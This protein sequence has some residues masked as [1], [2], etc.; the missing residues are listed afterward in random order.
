[1]SLLRPY[2]QFFLLFSF[3]QGKYWVDPNEGCYNDAEYVY[4]DFERGAT[5]VFP[6]NKEVR[7]ITTLLIIYLPFIIVNFS[8]APSM[9]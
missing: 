4:C 2:Y 7:F 6:D 9:L 3:L 1:M 5:C 8:R